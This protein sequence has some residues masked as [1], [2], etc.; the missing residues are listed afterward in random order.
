MSIILE[1]RLRSEGLALA[2]TLAAADVSLEIEGITAFGPTHPQLFAWVEGDLSGFEAALAEDPTVTEPTTLSDHGERRL[3]R[4]RTTDAVETVLYSLW[5]EAGGEGLSARFEDGWWHSRLRFP[6]R[7]AAAA[8]RDAL[9]AEGVTFHLEG[10]YEDESDGPG[11]SLT[12]EQ[13]ETLRLAYRRGYFSVPRTVSTAALAEELGV[14]AQA[15]SE[16]LRRGYARL[17]ERYVGVDDA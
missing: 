15:V 8:Y 2:P 5:V 17:V 3:Y 1:Y 7:A 13:R 14:S 12:S 4:V 16:R 9:T 6:S 10:I 11:A